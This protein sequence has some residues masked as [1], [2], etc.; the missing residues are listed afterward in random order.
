MTATAQQSDE[1]LWVV[2]QAGDE[3]AFERF[4]RR[5]RRLALAVAARICGDEAE[6][7]VQA[8]F[9]SI[10]RNRASYSEAKGSARNWTMAVVRNRAIDAVRASQ[11][12][13]ESPVGES[14][15]G[16]PDP[17]RTEE[18]AVER[19]TAHEL[20]AAIAGLPIRQR[21][22]LELGYFSELSQSEIAAALGL[23]LGTVKGRSRAALRGLSTVA[24]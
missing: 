9:L 11:R 21:Q 15:A 1:E 19:E 22:V 5:H 24:S 14:L 6:D 7:A 2:A 17:V 20:R 4:Y 12:R 23:P 10:W 3:V 18:L 8:A 16:V 13:R